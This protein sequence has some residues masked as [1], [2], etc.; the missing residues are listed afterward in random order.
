M[1]YR[2]NWSPRALTDVEE[3]AHFIE[4]DSLFYAQ[5]VVTKIVRSI[6]KLADFPLVGRI[7]PEFNQ[8]DFRELFVYSYRV[9]YR[10]E[11]ETV[12]VVAIIHGKRLLLPG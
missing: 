12:T 3:I 4:K 2:V 5:A 10:V 9:I 1:A 8:P 6:A 7:V 11:N